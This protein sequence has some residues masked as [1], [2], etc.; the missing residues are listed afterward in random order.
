MILRG[1]TSS[2][3]RKASLL[4]FNVAILTI[5]TAADMQWRV[6][7]QINFGPGASL[8]REMLLHGD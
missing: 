4:S 8:K 5:A 2:A 7:G 1:G 6:S 3:G